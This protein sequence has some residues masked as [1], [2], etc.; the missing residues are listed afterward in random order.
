MNGR[1]GQF[2]IISLRIQSFFKVGKLV[3]PVMHIQNFRNILTYKCNS[4]QPSS[5]CAFACELIFKNFLYAQAAQAND[6]NH[7]TLRRLIL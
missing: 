2:S 6:K 1:F 7:G 5:P 4:S 3:E